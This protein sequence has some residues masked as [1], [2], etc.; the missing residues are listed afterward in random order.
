[1]RGA[2]FGYED[3]GFRVSE[4]SRI[5]GS[6]VGVQNVEFVVEVGGLGFRSKGFKVS[7]FQVSGFEA[8]CFRA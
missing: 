7:S 4:E 8:L 6:R 2:E 5:K 1:M 3:V